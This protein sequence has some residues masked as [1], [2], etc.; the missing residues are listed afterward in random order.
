MTTTVTVNVNGDY[1]AQ[2]SISRNGNG[3]RE[4]GSQFWHSSGEEHF[5]LGGE[6]KQFSV[7][8]D[9]NLHISEMSKEQLQKMLDERAG[10]QNIGSVSANR[11]G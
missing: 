6:E 10:N 9:I 8:S 2:V 5:V 1:V 7:S 11:I 3:T 4:D